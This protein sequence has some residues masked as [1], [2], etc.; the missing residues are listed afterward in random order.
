MFNLLLQI[1]KPKWHLLD[2]LR[3][4]SVYRGTWTH[5]PVW[6]SLPWGFQRQDEL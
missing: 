2:T 5:L 3:E 1:G 6:R 4:P